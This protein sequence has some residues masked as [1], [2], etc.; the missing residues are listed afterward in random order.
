MLSLMSQMKVTKKGQNS[1]YEHFE[2]FCILYQF[3]KVYE[4]S[5]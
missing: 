2:G 5:T 1:F 4:N 3:V